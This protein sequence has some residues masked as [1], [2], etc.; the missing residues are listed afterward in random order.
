MLHTAL[1]V[2]KNVASKGTFVKTNGAQ[3][4]V[5]RLVSTSS[6]KFT[7]FEKYLIWCYMSSLLLKTRG[8]MDNLDRC[9]AIMKVETSADDTGLTSCARDSW[10]ARR[11]DL[12]IT[13]SSQYAFSLLGWIGSKVF[14]LLT[15]ISNY[16][17]F[18][19][20]GIFFRTANKLKY[21]FVCIAIPLLC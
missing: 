12:I 14:C 15:I 2:G 10:T 17:W 4:K 1:F 21:S 19:K 8:T 18:C 6:S 13:P 5:Q 9:F 16:I 3:K 20:W 7:T 11:V